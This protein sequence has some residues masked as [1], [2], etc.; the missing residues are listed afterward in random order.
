LKDFEVAGA[1]GQ[2]EP[3]LND[4]LVHAPAVLAVHKAGADARSA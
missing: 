4:D 2:G 1:P 3:R